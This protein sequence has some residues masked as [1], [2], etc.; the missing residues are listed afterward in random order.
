MFH[1][2]HFG[3]EKYKYVNKKIRFVRKNSSYFF[4]YSFDKTENRKTYAKNICIVLYNSV[5][6]SNCGKYFESDII[7]LSIAGL[8][9]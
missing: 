1:V 6:F 8:Y 3:C 2:E 4:I 5:E 7:E 9:A